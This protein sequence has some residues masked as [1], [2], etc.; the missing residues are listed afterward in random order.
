MVKNLVNPLS[1]H[2]V[3]KHFADGFNS[4]KFQ[5]RKPKGKVK[6]RSKKPFSM[7]PW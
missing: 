7:I 6:M 2:G 4:L 1:N 3:N 5:L